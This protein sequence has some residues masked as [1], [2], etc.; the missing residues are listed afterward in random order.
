MLVRAIKGGGEEA[1]MDSESKMEK[2]GAS[3]NRL[4]LEGMRVDKGK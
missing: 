4:K 3:S 2:C 1:G